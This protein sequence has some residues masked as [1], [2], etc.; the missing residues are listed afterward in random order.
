[1][2]ASIAALVGPWLQLSFQELTECGISTYKGREATRRARALPGAN[3]SA[4]S[5]YLAA[6]TFQAMF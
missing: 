6:V 2:N 1:M 3:S 5:I 4:S